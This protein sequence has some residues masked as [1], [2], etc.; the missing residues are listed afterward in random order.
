MCHAERQQV[1]DWLAEQGATAD[2]PEQLRAKVDRASE[3]A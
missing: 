2:S 1:Y 3:R